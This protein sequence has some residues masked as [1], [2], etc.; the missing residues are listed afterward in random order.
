MAKPRKPGAVDGPALQAW[1]GRQMDAAVNRLMR[2]G[3][4]ASV[5]VEA[6]PAWVLPGT[7][8]IGKIRDQDRLVGFDWFICG[9]APLSHIDSSL[10]ATPREAARHFA[11]QWH[12]DATRLGGAGADLAAKAGALYELVDED[13]FWQQGAS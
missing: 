9:D 11:L 5:K 6:K 13:V 7:L 8:L 10:A 3:V 12:L 1:I 2:R 4:V